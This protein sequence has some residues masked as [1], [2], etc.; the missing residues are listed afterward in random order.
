MIMLRVVRIMIL[1][2]TAIIMIRSSGQDS[3]SGIHSGIMDS[4]ITGASDTI[5]I[6]GVTIPI[7]GAIILRSGEAGIGE[8]V[9]ILL[10]DRAPDTLFGKTS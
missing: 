1:M 9:I 8:A 2:T 10:T 5:L 4:L 3:A 6:I 7:I